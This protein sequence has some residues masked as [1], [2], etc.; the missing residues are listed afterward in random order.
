MV[1]FALSCFGLLLFLWL[2]FGGPIPL[3]PKGYRFQVSFPEATQLAKEADVR[4]SGVPVGKVRTIEP[5]TKTGLTVA[6]IEMDSQYAPVRAD[7]K[8]MLRQKTLL[9]ETY[10]ELTPG[11]PGSKAVAENG[12]LAQGQVAPTVELDEILRAFDPKTRKAWQT[13]MQAQAQGIDGY[14]RDIN[15]ALGNLGPFAEDTAT[16]VDI[17]NRQQGAVT[18]LISNSGEVFGALTERQGELRSLIRNSNKVFETTAAR[19]KEL[20]E[21]FVALPTFEDESRVTVRRLA[22]FSTDTNPLVSQLRPAARELSPTLIDLS[23]LAPDLKRLFVELN[24]LIDASKTGFPAAQ[25]VLRDARPL[26]AQVDPAAQ[27]LVPL[28]DFVGLYKP[29]LTSFFA[30]VVGAT[31]ARSTSTRV[32]YLRTTNPFNPEN[33]AVYPRRLGTN[34]PNPYAQPG[35]FNK[36]RSGLEVYEDRHCGR[37]IPGVSNQ[38]LPLP[39]VVPTPTAVPPL[40]GLPVPVP[41][42]VPALP[43]TEELQ[44]LVPNDL[45]DRIN[46]FAFAN[47]PA[48]TAPAPPC[49]KQAP[50]RYGGETTQYPHVKA[51]TGR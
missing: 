48:G 9:G 36:L 51:G 25:Q 29:E 21:T 41:P 4:I 12:A 24:P 33:L 38:A 50:Y 1:I 20:Q 14:G 37:A 45:L 17:L 2:A 27:Q 49:K 6:V 3:K 8:A 5:D 44:A 23:A 34:R 28:L 13:W 47:A 16:L 39:E 18:R 30:N 26:L 32:H 42:V 7:T 15:D 11:T 31:Q 10:V 40:P 43:T 46:K 19:D 35:M 22:E